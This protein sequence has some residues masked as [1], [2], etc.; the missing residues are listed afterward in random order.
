MEW[1]R[2]VGEKNHELEGLRRLGR[3]RRAALLSKL[4]L[5][6]HVPLQLLDPPVSSYERLPLRVDGLGSVPSLLI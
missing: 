4:L 5:P 2:I 1:R 3:L 6:P